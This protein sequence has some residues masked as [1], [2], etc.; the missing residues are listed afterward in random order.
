[1]LQVSKEASQPP[2]I[3]PSRLCSRMEALRR[4]TV[5]VGEVV[6]VGMGGG[7]G[8]CGGVEGRWREK[9]GVR[10]FHGINIH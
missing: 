3:L 5:G 9:E 4:C 7:Q 6:A 2:V 1:M 10:R 8:G